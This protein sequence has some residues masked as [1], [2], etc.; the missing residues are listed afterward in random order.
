MRSYRDDSNKV[1][2]ESKLLDKLGRSIKTTLFS[3]KLKKIGFSKRSDQELIEYSYRINK[4]YSN[5][6]LTGDRL[7]PLPSLKNLSRQRY[8][9]KDITIKIENIKQTHPWRI[10]TLVLPSNFTILAPKRTQIIAAESIFGSPKPT[11]AC[12][13]PE[14][15]KTKQR[16]EAYFAKIQ[17]RTNQ[18]IQNI[19]NMSI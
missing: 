11:Q 6:K 10:E 9:N 7:K 3:N 19:L 14:K 2:E 13:D 1:I 8:R 4:P 16:L 12:P 18:K 5:I 15:A 17:E